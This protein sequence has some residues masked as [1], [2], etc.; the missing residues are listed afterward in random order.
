MRKVNISR[1]ANTNVDLNDSFILTFDL[2]DFSVIHYITRDTLRYE[3]VSDHNFRFWFVDSETMRYV[4]CND[5]IL[6]AI[7]GN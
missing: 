6:M 4:A 5:V 7:A 3:N 2:R 1:N